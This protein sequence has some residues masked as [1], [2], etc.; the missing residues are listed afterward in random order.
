MI[1]PSKTTLSQVLPWQADILQPILADYSHL[2]VTQLNYYYADW[3]QQ[4]VSFIGTEAGWLQHCIQ[5]GLFE[6]LPTRLHSLVNL[7]E[8]DASW[9]QAYQ[10][11]RTQQGLSVNFLKTDICLEGKHGFHLLEIGHARPLTLFDMNPLFDCISQLKDENMRLQQHHP[12]LILRIGKT[13]TAPKPLQL[14]TSSLFDLNQI[15]GADPIPLNEMETTV[16]TLRLQG[17]QDDEIAQQL[18]LCLADTRQLFASIAQKHH[19][20]CIPTSV[21]RHHLSHTFITD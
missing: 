4:I 7:W 20:P 11:Y 13:I 8:P 9:Y 15:E 18:K 1:K 3:Q 2:A 17:Y 21:Y 19:H 10:Q 14:E 12:E 16:L 5:E 6:D